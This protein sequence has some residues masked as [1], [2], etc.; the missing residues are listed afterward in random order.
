MCRRIG[1]ICA[2]PRLSQLQ[3]VPRL[4]RLHDGFADRQR[5]FH[6]KNHAQIFQ[7]LAVRVDHF[8]SQR[9]Q[10]YHENALQEHDDPI[11][12]IQPHIYRQQSVRF[13]MS[14]VNQMS[15]HAVVT[16]KPPRPIRTRTPTRWRTKAGTVRRGT[17]GSECRRSAEA[18]LSSR[19]SHPWRPESRGSFRA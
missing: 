3:V 7:I 15:Q 4:P 14:G 16:H 17:P 6:V 2:S 13:Q 12:N 18:D 10:S 11:Q 8:R 19:T 5:V 1:N 9:P